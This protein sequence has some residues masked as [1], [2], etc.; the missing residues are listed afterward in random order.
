M[1]ASILLCTTAA[2]TLASAAY[3]KP[4]EANQ[5]FFTRDIENYLAPDD[6]TLYLRIH[7]ND[8][9]RIDLANECPNLNTGGLNHISLQTAPGSPTVCH[10]VDLDL[11]V[12]GLGVSA[13]CIVKGLHKLTPDEVA[14]LPKK[15]KP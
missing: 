5:C 15:D 7:N 1:K 14:A 8:I 9:Y 4:H 10:A 12:S 6:H 3:A 13:P 11:R 2:L